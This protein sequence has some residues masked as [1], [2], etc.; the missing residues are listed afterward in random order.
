MNTTFDFKVRPQWSAQTRL[1]GLSL[2]GG[3]ALSGQAAVVA[4]AQDSLLSDWGRSTRPPITVNIQRPTVRV[5]PDMAPP[6]SAMDAAPS[7]RTSSASSA[8]H[9][10]SDSPT[11]VILD[12]DK[13][14]LRSWNVEMTDSTVRLCLK[15]WAKDAGWQ[16]VWDAKRDFVI[17][18]EVSFFG[19]FEQALGSIM[20]SLSDSEYPLQARINPD[21]KVVRIQRLAPSQAR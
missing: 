15:R 21:T 4:G 19:T 16:L 6:V 20:Q 9:S 1:L 17:D 14:K 10:N 18:S 5:Q 8:I 2:L 3:C 7:G 13:T 11:A 12:A